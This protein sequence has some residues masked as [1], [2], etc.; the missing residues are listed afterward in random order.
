MVYNDNYNDICLESQ[1]YFNCEEFYSYK[2]GMLYF[3]LL[4]IIYW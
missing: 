1:S 3:Q 2:N 4:S